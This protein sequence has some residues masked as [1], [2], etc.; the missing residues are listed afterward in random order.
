MSSTLAVAAC[1]LTLKNRVQFAV[2]QD[3]LNA[4]VTT[5]PPDRARSSNTGNQL[6]LY[7]YELMI[8]PAWRN[9]VT[10]R[11]L[12]G[13]EHVSLAPLG[14]SARY[15]LTAYAQDDE[16]ELAHRLL[17][18]AM[19]SLHDQALLSAAELLAALP[20]SDLHAQAEHARVTPHPLGLDELSK[21]WTTFQAP[22]R[23]TV[24]YEVSVL[25]ID[26]R[27][28]SRAALPVAR[29][30]LRPPVYDLAQDPPPLV[31]AGANATSGPGP[32]LREVRPPDPLPAV[33]PGEAVTWEVEHSAA[34]SVTPHLKHGL[35]PELAFLAPLTRA[36]T[37]SPFLL[38]VPSETAWP[39][40]T[41]QAWLALPGNP[42][43]GVSGPWMT[44]TVT[45]TLAPVIQVSPATAPA[46]PLTLNV[47]CRPAVRPTQPV[48]LLIHGQQLPPAS[49]SPD[50]HQMGFAVPAL[51]AGT[52][53]LRLRVDGVDSLPVALIDSA[54]PYQGAFAADQQLVLT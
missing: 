30:P 15:L 36:D 50:G 46:G 41:Y 39:V 53:P 23:A 6:N 34:L 54:H 52:Y 35:D 48:L 25:L 11:Q 32:A 16:D 31:D 21:L 43:S 45:F 47:T 22:Y 40:G 28:P 12:R 26:S 27:Q 19:L 5:R 8:S 20:A 1:T 44:N 9:E 7:L 38:T 14:L 24:A 49:R 3:G 42:D 13:G 33:R 2:D 18:S 37:A 51:P 29:R 17:G 4:V 10:P